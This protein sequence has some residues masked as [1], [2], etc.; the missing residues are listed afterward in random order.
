MILMWKDVTDDERKAIIAQ[1]RF[2]RAHFHFDAKRMWN[3]IPYIT[4]KLLKPM[5]MQAMYGL[6]LKQIFNLH[7]IIFLKHGLQMRKQE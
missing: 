4:E 2:L 6:K 3:K 5:I 1:A 7:M